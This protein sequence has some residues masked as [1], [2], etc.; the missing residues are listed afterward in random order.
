MGA[1]DVKFKERSVL[2]LRVTCQHQIWTVNQTYMFWFLRNYKVV[3]NQE[4]AFKSSIPE[5]LGLGWKVRCASAPMGAGAAHR[6]GNFI[7]T[8]TLQIHKIPDV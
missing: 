5:A 7:L 8:H 3:M 4:L 2:R 1:V 6:M